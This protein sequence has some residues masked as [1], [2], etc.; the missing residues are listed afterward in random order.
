MV[1]VDPQTR[2]EPRIG[3]WYAV[4][5]GQEVNLR[6]VFVNGTLL[7][8][9]EGV[10]VAGQADWFEPGNQSMLEI[11]LARVVWFGRKFDAT[12]L[13]GSIEETGSSY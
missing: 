6:R 9:S 7:C 11:L 13:T 8:L 4:N 5:L 10:P 1:D 2:R 3:A 12:H